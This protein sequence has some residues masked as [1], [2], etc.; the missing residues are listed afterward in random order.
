MKNVFFFKFKFFV[1]QI[2]N[3]QV[4]DI[5]ILY[6]KDISEK[7]CNVHQNKIKYINKDKISKKTHTHIYIYIYVYMPNNSYKIVMRTY[8]ILL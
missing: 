6:I 8:Y 7:E 4:F 1:S 3:G 5:L 2:S